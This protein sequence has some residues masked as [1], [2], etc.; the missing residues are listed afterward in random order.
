M[1][2]VKKIEKWQLSKWWEIKQ[3]IEWLKDWIY[4]IEIKKRGDRTQQQNKYYRGTIIWTIAK[5]TWNNPEELHYFF[6][7]KFLYP[8]NWFPSS[9]ELNKEEFADFINS[10]IEEAMKLGIN[11]PQAEL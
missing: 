10:I 7:N 1:Y 8:E 3:Y 5:E 11:I 6:K 2:F 9:K 4:S